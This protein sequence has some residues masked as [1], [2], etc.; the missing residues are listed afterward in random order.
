MKK[1]KKRRLATKEA[2]KSGKRRRFSGARLGICQLPPKFGRLVVGNWRPQL[3]KLL[4]SRNFFWVGLCKHLQLPRGDE[5]PPICPVSPE[6]FE[7]HRDFSPTDTFHGDTFLLCT[8]HDQGIFCVGNI[9]TRR[10]SKEHLTSDSYPKYAFQMA[11]VVL[12]AIVGW[13][14]STPWKVYFYTSWIE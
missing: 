1:K 12:F 8:N 11:K 14:K 2:L 9:S 3:S 13:L 6:S 7:R 10:T 4:R 5:T